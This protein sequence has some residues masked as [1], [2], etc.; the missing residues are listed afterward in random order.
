MSRDLMLQT[1]L[2]TFLSMTAF[3]ANAVI[4]RWA[5]DHGLIDPVSFTSLRLGS[6]ALAL[7]VVMTLLNWHKAKKT[8]KQTRPPASAKISHG[9]WSAAIFLFLYALT[10]SYGY[11]AISTATGALVLATVVQFTMIGY[12]LKKGDK[13]HQAEWLGVA[14][15]FVGLVY[16]VYPKLTTPSWWA[17]LMVVAS[18]YS[19]GLY[20]LHGQKSANPMSDTAFNFYRTLP[21]V[22]VASLL[23][24]LLMADD[25]FISTK[26]FW[27]AV[28]SGAATTGLGYII[29]YAALPRLSASLASASQLVVP[30]MAA[31]GA[32]WLIDEPIT[33]R[34]MLAAAVMIAGLSLVMHGRNQHRKHLLKQNAVV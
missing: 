32:A 11:V 26:G 3:A 17:L 12:A 14:L 24:W 18:A 15:A 28:M 9:S 29:W 27:L 4:C 20:T 34:F 8:P 5:L 1:A 25:I 21:M 7:F 33:L 19:W 16:L 31:F 30:L 13:L 23:G 10:F 6:A 2:F 22:A